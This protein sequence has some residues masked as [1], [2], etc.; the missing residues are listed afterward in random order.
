MSRWQRVMWSSEAEEV[1]GVYAVFDLGT[2]QLL[3]IGSSGS[4]VNTVRVRMRYWDWG[5]GGGKEFYFKWRGS[6]QIGG[7]RRG[8]CLMAEIRLIDRLKPPGNE[9]KGHTL[10]V[11][12]K[13]MD[14]RFVSE[15]IAFKKGKRNYRTYKKMLPE[16]T[17]EEI[18]LT[19]LRF[20]R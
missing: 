12:A 2:D 5:I 20:A 1:E 10:N 13:L 17:D 11:D 3:Y 18:Q 15:L 19:R 16:I 9:T 8:E 7:R 14:G 4:N 6:I